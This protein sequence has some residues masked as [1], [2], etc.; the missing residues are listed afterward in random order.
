[1]ADF[2][3]MM[4]PYQ[5]PPFRYWAQKILP[6]VY[7]DSLSYYEL[8]DRVVQKLNETIAALNKYGEDTAGAVEAIVEIRDNLEFYI[9]KAINEDPDTKDAI[10]NAIRMYMQTPYPTFNDMIEASHVDGEVCI[11][12]GYNT[13]GD[14]GDGLYIVGSSY[15]E[16]YG[17]SHN[18]KIFSTPSRKINLAEWGVLPGTDISARFNQII[19]NASATNRN[20][21]DIESMSLYFSDGLYYVSEPLSIIPAGSVVKGTN[22]A[23]PYQRKGDVVDGI[24][25]D[26]TG[27]TTLVFKSHADGA[28]CM[29]TSSFCRVEG[30][31][32]MSDGSYK[33]DNIAKATEGDIGF[34]YHPANTNR[35]EAL[36]ESVYYSVNGLDMSVN[37]SN[38][39]AK[40][41]RVNDCTFVGFGGFGLKPSSHALIS[42]CS[43]HHCHIGMIGMDAQMTDNCYFGNGGY[44]IV[45]GNVRV[46]NTWFDAMV[47]HAIYS[48]TNTISGS[49]AAAGYTEQPAALIGEISGCV[50]DHIQYSAIK[51]RSCGYHGLVINGSFSRCG[52]Y[53]AGLSVEA[54][55]AE[56]NDCDTIQR[57]EEVID[58]MCAINIPVANNLKVKGS[59]ASKDFVDQNHDGSFNCPQFAI[60]AEEFCNGYLEYTPYNAYSKIVYSMESNYWWT[61]EGFADDKITSDKL[62]YKFGEVDTGKTRHSSNIYEGDINDTG[63]DMTYHIFN[64]VFS[65][66]KTSFTKTAGTYTMASIPGYITPYEGA[67]LS[68][69][70]PVFST[71]KGYVGYIKFPTGVNSRNPQPTLTLKED[72]TNDIIYC[73]H[74]FSYCNTY[75]RSV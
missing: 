64:N 27:G 75:P 42:H 41:C 69:I 50:F 17:E 30:I 65:I 29:K 45:S 53:R 58:G 43:F 12:R 55:I 37:F 13:P 72:L 70:I 47:H 24:Y 33:W 67:T 63:L 51:A 48:G 66:F 20:G 25:R 8:L 74:D 56:L 23:I 19:S 6:A 71:S 68:N 44:G 21:T 73:E 38:A 18:G 57:V 61:K 34:S 36:T 28:T 49:P 46:S 40:D 4:L 62:R 60:S 15:T 10:D 22:R 3:S 11:T 7:D 35:Y 1:M 14:G 5:M 2:Q 31:L 39:T 59:V 32:F 54:A 52:F 9:L 26:Y 16:F